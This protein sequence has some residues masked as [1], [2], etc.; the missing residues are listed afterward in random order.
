MTNR[1]IDNAGRRAAL[2]AVVA[3]LAALAAADVA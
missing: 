2:G 1:M 3:I